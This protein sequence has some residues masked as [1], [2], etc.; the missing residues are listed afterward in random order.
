MDTLTAPG[1]QSLN[2]AVLEMSEKPVSILC[3]DLIILEH[4]KVSP[5]FVRGRGK[6]ELP[7]PGQAL[8]IKAGDLPP[9]LNPLGDFGKL[10]ENC[11]EMK[12]VKNDYLRLL[13]MM[14]MM[15]SRSDSVIAVPEGKHNPRLSKSSATFPPPPLLRHIFAWCSLLLALRC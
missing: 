3:L 11:F 4:I 15:R 5:S 1:N 2:P 8:V 13:S 6:N 14:E 10:T 9:S 7:D 12:S